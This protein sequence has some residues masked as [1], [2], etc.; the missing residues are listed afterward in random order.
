MKL[1]NQIQYW[2]HHHTSYLQALARKTDKAPEDLSQLE[3]ARFEQQYSDLYFLGLGA[4]YS[5]NYILWAAAE[6]LVQN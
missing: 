3:Q 5:A 4:R 2:W 6:R 1:Q